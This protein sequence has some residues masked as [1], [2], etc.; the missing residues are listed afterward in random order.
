LILYGTSF[1]SNRRK[2]YHFEIPMNLLIGNISGVLKLIKSLLQKWVKRNMLIGNIS[3][4]LKLSEKLAAKSRLKAFFLFA[5]YQRNQK[6]KKKMSVAAQPPPQPPPPPPPGPGGD[7]NDLLPID[8]V[9]SL[10]RKLILELAESMLLAIIDLSV[11]DNTT[12]QVLLR[13]VAGLLYVVFERDR[14][15]INDNPFRIEN[16]SLADMQTAYRGLRH[17]MAVKVEKPPLWNPAAVPK[18]ENWRR[19]CSQMIYTKF[20]RKPGRGL[21]LLR[22][23]TGSEEFASALIALVTGGLAVLTERLSGTT[24]QTKSP[25]HTSQFLPNGV[26]NLEILND[27]GQQLRNAAER[28]RWS[29]SDRRGRRGRRGASGE[30]FRKESIPAGMDPTQVVYLYTAFEDLTLANAAMN[31][32][33]QNSTGIQDGF[34]NMV[35][36]GQAA[37][38]LERAR[39]L[40]RRTSYHFVPT[41]NEITGFVARPDTPET[42]TQTVGLTPF[43]FDAVH[44]SAALFRALEVSRRD[45]STL[46]ISALNRHHYFERLGGVE[47]IGLLQR[48]IAYYLARVRD[49]LAQLGFETN[50]II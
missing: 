19:N 4:A 11:H 34:R 39:S 23:E 26:A 8:A 47:R 35:I 9:D 2:L 45:D 17:D 6:K 20:C 42:H 30:G 21:S 37:S 10:K 22:L 28:I 7:R 12:L 3:G 48:S 40:L 46:R 43:L 18:D 44:H 24:T 5:V 14:S 13:T 36:V 27:Y 50:S 1:K 16:N 38:L 25:R 41:D 49:V 31:L 29:A 33:Q 15:L 32:S